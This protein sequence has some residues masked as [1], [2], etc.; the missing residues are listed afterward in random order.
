MKIHRNQECIA[1]K[2]TLTAQPLRTPTWKQGAR[3][4]LA[5]AGSAGGE[6]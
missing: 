4:R 3:E 2:S 5:N 1:T 6:R